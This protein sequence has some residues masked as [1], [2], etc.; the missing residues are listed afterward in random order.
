MAENLVVSGTGP[1][2]VSPIIVVGEMAVFT[3]TTASSGIVEW[4]IDWAIYSGIQHLVVKVT[5]AGTRLTIADIAPS[6]KRG[7]SNLLRRLRIR[8]PVPEFCLPD[9]S[10][11][12][13]DYVYRERERKRG[14]NL[15]G[16]GNSSLRMFVIITGGK[17][18]CTFFSHCPLLLHLGNFTRV[19]FALVL[20]HSCVLGNTVN[21]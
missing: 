13:V 21:A 17:G 16:K 4:L 15:R 3:C 8:C 6:P 18:E 9:G 14:K 12:L 10:N 20:Q 1:A 11:V 5:I 19:F 2:R 7:Q